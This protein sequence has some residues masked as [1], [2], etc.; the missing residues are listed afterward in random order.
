MES[1]MHNLEAQLSKYKA[2]YGDLN[3]KGATSG[4]KKLQQVDAFST[5]QQLNSNSYNG[6]SNNVSTDMILDT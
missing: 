1:V 6:D 5:K 4:K 3:R 2:L